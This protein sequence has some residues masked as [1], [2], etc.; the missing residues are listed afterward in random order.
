MSI[1][2]YFEEYSRHSADFAR[3]GIIADENLEF[4]HR[5]ETIGV[6][7]GRIIFSDGSFLSLMEFVDTGFADSRIT[8]SYHYQAADGSQMFRYDNASHR[9]NVSLK[10]TN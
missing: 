6:I 2:D 8:Y 10:K 5:T 3:I 4:D 7:R 9:W 1:A